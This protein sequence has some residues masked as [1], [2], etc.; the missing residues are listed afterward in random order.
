VAFDKK[1][2]TDRLAQSNYSPLRRKELFKALRPEESRYDEFRAALDEL[3]DDGVVVLGRG[4][5]YALAAASG[6][7]TG[8]IEI[9]RGQFG[10]V[11]PRD[12]G[13]ADLFVPPDAT[14]GALD[15]DTVLVRTAKSRGRKIARV[16]KVVR[17]ARSTVAGVFVSTGHGGVVIPDHRALPEFEID[18]QDLGGA[19]DGEKVLVEPM[20][21]TYGSPPVARVVRLLGTAGTWTA[22]RAARV[23]EFEL[24]TE[25]ADDV[26][27]EAARAPADIPAE[28]AARRADHTAEVV[29]AIDPD[30]ARD[31]DDAFHVRRNDDGTW[32]LRVHIADVAHYV[33][34]GGAVD[35]E[36]RLRST[37]VYLP[38]EVFRMLPD[39]LSADVCS[40]L[41]GV[42]RLVKTVSMRYDADGRR[43][44]FTIER[45]VIETRRTLSYGRV[46]GALEGEAVDEIDDE[47]LHMLRR[48]RELHE[49]LRVNRARDGS[50]DFTFPEVRVTL[51]PE[52]EVTGIVRRAS[53]YTHHM[54]EEFM[55]EANR[56][57][58]ELCVDWGLP[59]LHR[60]HEEPDER[61]LE[62]FAESARDMGYA[63]KR[64]YTR[65]KLRE[66]L[67][68]AAAAG[69]AGEAVAF[70]L[71]RALK[72][73]RYYEHS[74]GHYALAFE[75]YLHFTS[76]I[77]RYPDLV[78]HRA[79]DEVFPAGRP[80]LPKRKPASVRPADG[81]ALADL[82]HLGEHCS[83]RERAAEK[84]EQM[85]TRFRQME[86]LKEHAG[87][88]IAAVVRSVDEYGLGVELEEFWVRARAPLS[89]LPPDRYRFDARR[90][91][92][93]GKRSRFRAGDRVRT[94]VVEV[95]LVAR[96]V[97]V[98]V[99]LGA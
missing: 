56:C 61:G 72:L 77:R 45:S 28:E 49:L 30:D 18:P 78:V 87:G 62:A 24:R 25:F 50:L 17:R 31:H 63:F 53:D 67:D 88:V 54:V 2:I 99:L 90:G 46:F 6:M 47:T 8:T 23:A 4:R 22:E 29:V 93:N 55:L 10:F 95:D 13:A 59:V 39:R 69:E 27:E 97:V 60:I 89:K 43:T 36:A 52:G 57:V 85:L 40:L 68:R 81:E 42:R 11:K 94:R 37:S 98:T 12:A 76:P 32:L 82:A 64:P 79:L 35:R 51:S 86:F 92:L 66:L 15:G 5:R 91:A 19:T 83:N 1:L 80:A 74:V 71:L 38:G 65:R 84:A 21:R 16:E 96:E 48:A 26:E 14:G 73:A 75:R 70:A 33:P 58:A 7:F 44:S 20:A 3:V 9:K 34:A 41:G